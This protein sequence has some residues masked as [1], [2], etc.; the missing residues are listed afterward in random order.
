MSIPTPSTPAMSPKVRAL[1]YAVLGWLGVIAF[2]LFVAFAAIPGADVPVWLNVGNAV[3]NGSGLV[4]FVA[5][6]NTP[7][8]N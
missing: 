4:F 3:L 2:L 5:K 8:Q 7:G 1:V 6:D